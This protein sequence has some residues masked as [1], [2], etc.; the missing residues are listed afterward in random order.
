MRHI[1]SAAAALAAVAALTS[2]SNDDPVAATR[3]TPTSSPSES[4]PGYTMLPDQTPT[5]LKAGRWAVTPAGKHD[6][7]LAVF[8]VP[9]RFEGGASW[10]VTDGGYIGYWTVDR[11][12]ANACKTISSTRVGSTTEALATA[13]VAQKRTTTTKPVPVSIDGHDGLYLELTTAPDV[14]LDNCTPDDAF[15]IWDTYGVGGVRGESEPVVDRYW[16]LDVFGQRVVLLTS[17]PPDAA[18]ATVEQL[19]SMVEAAT[20]SEAD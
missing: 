15:Y 4:D 19:T 7:P 8:G 14:S 11:V 10:L 17:V 2:C 9:K 13:L 6:A 18:T 5:S 1:N 3:T 16:I 12:Y 20:F